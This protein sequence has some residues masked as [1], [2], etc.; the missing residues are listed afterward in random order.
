[1]STHRTFL[2]RGASKSK[3]TV[4]GSEVPPPSQP[5]RCAYQRIWFFCH[6]CSQQAGLE[7]PQPRVHQLATRFKK[8]HQNSSRAQSGQ[9]ILDR[10][11]LNKRH[12]KGGEAWKKRRGCS[13]PVASVQAT[14]HLQRRSK[15]KCSCENMF[16]P[17][18][19]GSNVRANT[20]VWPRCTVLISC[21]EPCDHIRIHPF[22]A[23]VM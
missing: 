11:G 21:M 22:L 6:Q 3:D 2:C 12:G 1:M 19:K 8:H 10:V 17:P 18:K 13:R 14:G 9:A 16:D 23:D 7:K 5:P 15:C 4:P 20:H